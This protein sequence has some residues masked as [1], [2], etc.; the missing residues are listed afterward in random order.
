MLSS[1]SP[2]LDFAIRYGTAVSAAVWLGHVDGLVGD[3]SRW[4]QIAVLVVMQRTSTT[5]DASMTGHVLQK[6]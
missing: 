3:Q 6:Y 4:I 2:E 5:I 1:P